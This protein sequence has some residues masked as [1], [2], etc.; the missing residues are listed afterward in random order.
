[1]CGIAGIL[2]K[3]E[4]LGG[5]PPTAGNPT[6]ANV[7]NFPLTQPLLGTFG[8][9][10]RN[11]LRLEGLSKLDMGVYKNTRLNE[12]LTVQF[13]WETYNVFNHSNF[14]GFVNTL[15]APNFGT[16]TSTATDPR[17]MQFALLGGCCT[18]R[19]WRSGS[20][21]RS[22]CRRGWGIVRP[23]MRCGWFATLPRWGC[24]RSY[25]C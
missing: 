20:G 3:R 23:T 15:T 5:T 14:S 25:G 12:K 9:S 21:W 10:G 24:R 18:A 16:Y 13:R 11:H 1:M 19:A 22:G 2:Y 17:K 4:T 6:C 8:N 7:S